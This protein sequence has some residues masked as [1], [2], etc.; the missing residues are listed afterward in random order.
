MKVIENNYISE[1]KTC[2]KCKSVFAIEDGDFHIGD[3]GC[4]Y[5]TCPY[6]LT[7]NYVDEGETLTCDNLVYP[8]HFASFKSGKQIDAKELN[9]WAK[10]AV[11]ALDKDVDYAV[12]GSGNSLVFAYKSDPELNEVSVVVCDNGYYETF[13]EIPED[14]Y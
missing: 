8:Q 3:Y 2:E 4:K 12:H 14:K 7:E 9:K 5:W 13:V 10:E 1:R 6:C 11:A